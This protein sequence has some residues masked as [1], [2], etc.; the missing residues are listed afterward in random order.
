MVIAELAGRLHYALVLALGAAGLGLAVGAA[1]LMKRVAGLAMLQAALALFFVLAGA[2][3]NARAAILSPGESPFVGVY[4]N[5][6][7]QALALVVIVAGAATSTLALALV[8]RVREAYG[9]VEAPEIAAADHVA[10][11]GGE[12]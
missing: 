1:N 5:P 6:L 7:A 9:S 12:G 11:K 8:V 3:A 2:A 10:A 4:A